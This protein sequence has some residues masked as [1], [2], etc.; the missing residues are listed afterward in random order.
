VEDCVSSKVNN[1]TRKFI[2]TTFVQQLNEHLFNA[3]RQE[4]K[5]NDGT[6]F[7]MWEIKLSIYRKYDQCKKPNRIFLKYSI[8]IKWV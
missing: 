2:L 1:K 6:K 8:K 3:I 7:G 5:N 4:E